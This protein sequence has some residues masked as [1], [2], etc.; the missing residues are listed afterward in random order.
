[1]IQRSPESDR[2]VRSLL[3]ASRALVG[4]AARSLAETEEVTLPQYRALVVVS[5]QP[6]VTVTDL[7]GSLDVHPTTATRLT[8]RLVAKRLVRRTDDD[9][10][11]RI[12]RLQLTTR[13][14]RLVDTVTERRVQALRGIVA[15]M[16]VDSLPGVA[17]ALEE[18]AKAAGEVGEVDLFA[19]SASVE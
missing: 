1:V 13:G 14:K 17:R 12:T 19:W 9:D 6:G 8:D 11:R 4:V 15:A 16:D 7:A 5:S 10:D 2:A 18:F 3:L